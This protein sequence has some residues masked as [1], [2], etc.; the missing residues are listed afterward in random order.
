M[1]TKSPQSQFSLNCRNF[2]VGFSN[3][4]NP[5]P[6]QTIDKIDYS[7][8]GQSYS[9]SFKKKCVRLNHEHSFAIQQATYFFFQTFHKA[10]FVLLD[11]KLIQLATFYSNEAIKKGLQQVI[12]R[13][14]SE[15]TVCLLSRLGLSQRVIV[16]D[17][18][19]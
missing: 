2:S 19:R 14:T 4:I 3:P 5:F 6:F 12:S 13:L 16:A 18:G 1:L 15:L 10:S 9:S 7:C 8:K 11:T 17:R